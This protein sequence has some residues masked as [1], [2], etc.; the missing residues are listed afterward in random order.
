MSRDLGRDREQRTAVTGPARHAVYRSELE[1][2]VSAE[3][4]IEPP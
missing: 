3:G 4:E 2:S 1:G